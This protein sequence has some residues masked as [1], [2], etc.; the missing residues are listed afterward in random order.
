MKKILGGTI[1]GAL[2]GLVTAVFS[3]ARLRGIAGVIQSGLGGFVGGFSGR[4]PGAISGAAMT[5]S[6]MLVASSSQ[7]SYP[8]FRQPTSEPIIPSGVPVR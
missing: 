6:R 5:I 4:I 8:R 1:T 7:P 3:R 2:F